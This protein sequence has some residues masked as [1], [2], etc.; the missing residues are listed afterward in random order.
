MPSRMNFTLSQL[1][2]LAANGF[3]DFPVARIR[4][5]NAALDHVDARELSKGASIQ[6]KLEESGDA[7]VVFCSKHHCLSRREARSGV[8]RKFDQEG[9]TLILHIPGLLDHTGESLTYLFECLLSPFA[10]AGFAL[11]PIDEGPKSFATEPQLCTGYLVDVPAVPGHR[12]AFDH[13]D[14]DT[15]LRDV[16]FD[17]RRHAIQAWPRRM[18]EAEDRHGPRQSLQEPYP[19][20]AHL[21]K[22]LL[23]KRG[24][25]PLERPPV[26]TIDCFDALAAAPA[27]AGTV[28]QRAGNSVP[29][30]SRSGGPCAIEELPESDTDGASEGLTV[31][32][33]P[34]PGCRVLVGKDRASKS[35]K[36]QTEKDPKAA[37]DESAQ[38]CGLEAASLV[39]KL[40]IA[41][42]ALDRIDV[43]QY[44]SPAEQLFAA[45]LPDD[46]NCV[47]GKPREKLKKSIEHARKFLS[48]D[49]PLFDR[50]QARCKLVCDVFASPRNKYLETLRK[51]I[52]NYNCI[53]EHAPFLASARVMETVAAVY[54]RRVATV[55]RKT[56]VVALSADYPFAFVQLA[57]LVQIE[58]NCNQDGKE[59]IPY[60]AEAVQAFGAALFAQVYPAK[61]GR[62]EP[63]SIISGFVRENNRDDRQ[64]ILHLFDDFAP[65]CPGKSATSAGAGGTRTQSD[66]GPTTYRL[67]SARVVLLDPANHWHCEPNIV[68]GRPFATYPDSPGA[69]PTKRRL[70]VH[71][72]GNMIEALEVERSAFMDYRIIDVR[73]ELDRIIGG[74]ELSGRGRIDVPSAAQ[75][76]FSGSSA[77]SA[78][79]QAD[80]DWLVDLYANG[81]KALLGG[82]SPGEAGGYAALA[83]SCMRADDPAVIRYITETMRGKEQGCI[84]F[85]PPPALTIADLAVEEFF[86]SSVANGISQDDL[87]QSQVAQLAVL[88]LEDLEDT[89]IAELAATTDGRNEEEKKT[90]QWLRDPKVLAEQ[91]RRAKLIQAEWSSRTGEKNNWSRHEGSRSKRFV[92]RILSRSEQKKLA[93]LDS[94]S[95]S[96]AEPTAEERLQEALEL[97]S[98]KRMKFRRVIRGAN[99]L[100]RAGMLEFGQGGGV[101]ILTHGSHMVFHGR[102]GSTTLVREHKGSARITAPTFIKKMGALMAVGEDKKCAGGG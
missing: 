15:T 36:K 12:V 57:Y 5:V 85:L 11:V 54:R 52:R 10:F 98:R 39:Q 1:D 55:D 38:A 86:W 76:F 13:Y 60:T 81:K 63:V 94:A 23:E 56:G 30:F 44:L 51:H 49:G 100:R 75:I 24:G 29:A 43:K 27:A 89:K 88:M 59:R 77:V 62:R 20:G 48:E 26:T 42:E 102:G 79:Q 18:L 71:Q 97:I 21:R 78:E 31:M 99:L 22:M 72:H 69:S 87:D 83:N 33:K 101:R 40:A 70:V 53:D 47:R 17:R 7:V 58:Q 96:A 73:K 25:A 84:P 41:R 95:S 14:T 50:V 4:E 9:R 45:K 19:T 67:T 80:A 92:P 74:L 37:Q 82:F 90:L 2:L 64:F 91:R 65:L 32:G 61:I 46:T 28:G 68:A 66:A 93:E 6:Q 8:H 3:T 34:R 35:Q 16:G